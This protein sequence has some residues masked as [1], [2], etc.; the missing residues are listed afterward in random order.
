MGAP[1]SGEE[2]SLSMVDGGVGSRGCRRRSS[3]CRTRGIS[4]EDSRS[5]HEPLLRVPRACAAAVLAL[6]LAESASGFVAPPAAA[7]RGMCVGR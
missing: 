6:M 5:L 3:I 2:T 4:S 1:R 7:L